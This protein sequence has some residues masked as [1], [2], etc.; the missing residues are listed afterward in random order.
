MRTSCSPGTGNFHCGSCLHDEA[1][2]R[3]LRQLGH[4]VSISALYLPLVLDH[5]AGIDGDDVQM[6]GINLYLQTKSALFRHAPAFVERALNRPALLRKASN[7]ADMTSPKELGRMTEQMLLG[8]H[9]KTKHEIDRLIAHLRE[10]DTPDVVLLNNALLLGL[11]EPLKAAL[12]CAVACTL[13]GEDTF[14]DGLPD[15]WKTNAWR[16]LRE[17]AAY[18]DAFLPVSAYHGELMRGRMSL[19]GEKVTVVYN[20]IETDQYPLQEKPPDPPVV[21]YLARLCENKGLG[22]LVDAFI[23]LH[24]LSLDH[25]IALSIVGAATPKDMQYVDAQRDKLARQGLLDLVRIET[26]VSFDQK[27]KALRA[28]SVLSVPATYGESFGLY[29]LEANAVGV[30]AVEPDHAGL[31]EVI[32]QTGGGILYEPGDDHATS[33]ANALMSLLADDEARRQRGRIGRAAVMKRFTA[34]RMAE[35]VASVLEPLCQAATR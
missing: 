9:G 5:R 33:L 12:G 10:R 18:C 23:Q 28:M 25:D 3:T 27:I 6:G 21:G 17:T 29:V 8:E 11:A 34:T 20:G 2:V 14:I 4:D 22:T 19:P 16:L 30:P 13:Q 26:N 15:P 24:E 31:A 35:S 1:L 32:G 7:R